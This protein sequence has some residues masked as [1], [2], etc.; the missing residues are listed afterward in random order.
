MFVYMYVQ[1]SFYTFVWRG[2]SDEVVTFHCCYIRKHYTDFVCVCVFVCD[3]WAVYYIH[4]LCRC[5]LSRCASGP[6]SDKYCVLSRS[7]V[8]PIF[9]LDVFI[10]CEALFEVTYTRNETEK[11]RQ[12]A[13]DHRW[14]CI[15]NLIGIDTLLYDRRANCQKALN[16][17]KCKC[18]DRVHITSIDCT[19]K[20]TPCSICVLSCEKHT[21]VTMCLQTW[22][23]ACAC[24]HRHDFVSCSSRCFSC[25]SR[26][27][28]VY[29]YV[30]EHWQWLGLTN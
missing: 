9:A 18:T 8:K 16:I 14:V 28:F 7:F 26:L 3:S 27:V 12:V 2:R 15:S 21:A 22:Q 1:A 24:W 5:I 29:F 11:E 4:M 30:T 25:K 19:I 23:S 10:I 6:V 13:L 17:E 20:I